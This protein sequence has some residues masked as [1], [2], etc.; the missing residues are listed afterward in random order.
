MDI[1]FKE[2]MGFLLLHKL[3]FFTGNY[4]ILPNKKS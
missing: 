3:H 4:F 2:S 1:D